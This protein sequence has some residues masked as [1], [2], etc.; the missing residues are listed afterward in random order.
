MRCLSLPTTVVVAALASATLA[1][2]GEL[3]TDGPPLPS[4]NAS[5]GTENTFDH[6]GTNV[7]VWD[8]V[9][10]A[11]VEGPPRFAARVHSC[12][13]MKYATLGALL[14]S[15]GV[16]LGNT[17]ALS[18]GRLYRDGDQALGVANFGARQR[19]GREL[20]TATASKMFDIFV[21][22]APEIIANLG[23]RPECQIA[24]QG[25]PLFNVDDQ[26]NPDGI[27]CLIGVPATA[28]HVE[29][30]NLAVTRA[31]DVDKGKRIAVATLLAAANTC[32]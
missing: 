1:C 17:A 32:E 23:D 25:A 8:L 19:E 14:A 30:C 18:A 24:G 26:C 4:G 3:A 12:A 20:S 6:P 7:D 10:R 9:D 27:T 15:R 21:Q 11:K 22:A 2:T 16:D 31:S 28:S 5:G 29:L 13:K